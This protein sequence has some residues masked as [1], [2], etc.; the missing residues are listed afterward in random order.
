MKSR[1]LYAL[2]F[3]AGAAVLAVEILG[4]RILGPFYGMSLFLWSAL[5]TVTLASLSVGYVLGGRWADQGPKLARLCYVLAA[6]GVWLLLVPVLRHP[7]LVVAE[8]FGLRVAVLVATFILFAPPLTLLGMVSPYAI[9][10]KAEHLSEVGRTA[11]DLYALSTIGSVIAALATGFLLIPNVGVNRLTFLIGATLI[12]TALLGLLKA[13]GSRASGTTL[14][15]ILAI[16]LAGVGTRSSERSDPESGLLAVEQSAYAE[17]RVLDVDGAR[18]LLIDGS[19]HTLVNPATWESYFPYVATLEIAKGYFDRPGTMLLIG[20]GGGTVAKNYSRVGWRVD[21][22]EIDPVVVDVARRFF[23]LTDADA[24][25]FVVDG[26]KFLIGSRDAYDVIIMDAFGSS[27][28]PFHLITRESFG[29]IA[30]HLN[31]GGVLA[32]NLETL[33]W[34][35]RIVRAVTATVREQFDHVLALPTEADPEELGNIILLASD[36]ALDSAAPNAMPRRLP[37]TP[38]FRQA[39]ASRFIPDPRQAP[40]LTDDRNPID[41]WSE[42]VNHVA[43]KGLHG[44]FAEGGR[45]W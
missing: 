40:V 24:R 31:P 38:Q 37:L 41:L 26:R 27:S 32:V 14:F 39:W 28:I 1:Y 34:Q 16:A 19:L 3:I 33:G 22:V 9:R 2:V 17:I 7:V 36:R 15:G 35:D 29:L 44:Y 5:I 12:V 21:A 45:S 6:A 25:V 23:G 10:L 4:T 30:S 11:G 43:R 20:L 8:P 13:R 42:E 18:H